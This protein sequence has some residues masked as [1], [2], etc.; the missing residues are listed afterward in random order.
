MKSHFELSDVEFEQQFINCELDANAFS[1]EA[2]LRLAW[3]NIDKY[4]IE[5]AEKNLSTQLQK[6]VEFV[7]AKD[8]YNATLTIA[9]VKAVYHF[10][11]KST[12]D[13]FK[14]F[15]VEIPRLKYNFKELMACH[16]GFDI[17][18]S[19]QAKIEFLEPDLL[20]FDV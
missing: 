9:A 8:K 20:V 5:Q 17:Y 4:G 6:F 13:N 12:S 10:W 18:N 14:D 19:Q 3:I 1:H 15:I 7:G 2:H 11:Q 16:Y